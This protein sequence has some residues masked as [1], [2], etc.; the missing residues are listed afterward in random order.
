MDETDKPSPGTSLTPEVRLE[1]IYLEDAS[2]ESPLAP[3]VFAEPLE[4]RIQV[5]FNAT[6]KS[7]GGARYRVVLATRIEGRIREHETAFIIEVQQ[8]GIFAIE[9]FD[10]ARMRQILGTFCLTTLFPYVRESIDS[11]ALKGGFPALRLTPINFDALYAQ[12]VLRAEQEAE[13]TVAAQPASEG[14]SA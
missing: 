2:F 4:P 6:T 7:L 13:S 9:G 10:T 1:H 11:L 5:D 14:N 12:G 8:A 3:E